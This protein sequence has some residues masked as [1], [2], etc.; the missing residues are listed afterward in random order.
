MLVF[1]NYTHIVCTAVVPA[2]LRP[3]FQLEQCDM[4]LK[5]I[6]RQIGSIENIK[7]VLS[8]GGLK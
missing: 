7:V 8:M 3:L 1:E 4:K 5:A 6:L 2:F